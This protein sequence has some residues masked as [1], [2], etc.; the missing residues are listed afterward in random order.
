MMTQGSLRIGRFSVLLHRRG[1]VVAGVL[2]ALVFAIAILAVQLGRYPMALPQILATLSG[3]GDA[4]AEMI[5]LD[6]R[7]PRILTAIGAGA[8]F[9]FAGAMFQTMLRNP[10]ASPDVIGFSAGASCGALMGMMAFGGTFVLPGALIGG[11]LT[12]FAVLTMSLHRRIH[13]SP[14]ILLGIG[15]SLTLSVPAYLRMSPLYLLS[16]VE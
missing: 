7:L 13:P 16:A 8:A 6:N 14:L 5:V 9:G 11:L 15:A 4:I 12:A 10:L 1:I 2:L 3:G